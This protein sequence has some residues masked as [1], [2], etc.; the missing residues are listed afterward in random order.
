M[1]TSQHGNKLIKKYQRFYVKEEPV[2]LFVDIKCH[3]SFCGLP[4]LKR[5]ETLKK[6]MLHLF[7]IILLNDDCG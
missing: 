3:F 2:S 7:S 6:T 4:S 5:G 1:M